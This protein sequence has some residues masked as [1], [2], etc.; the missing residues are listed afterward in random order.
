MKY[1][2]FDSKPKEE[3]DFEMLREDDGGFGLIHESFRH[4]QRPR[5]CEMVEELKGW[6][7]KLQI[8]K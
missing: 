1:V 6:E 3:T 5:I 7:E 8:A 4:S 2:R